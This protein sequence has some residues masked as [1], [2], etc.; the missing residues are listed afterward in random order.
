M[1]N[2]FLIIVLT[3]F[4]LFEIESIYSQVPHRSSINLEHGAHR[5]G[6]RTD[7]AMENWRNYGLGQF[8]HWGIYSIPGG[9]WDGKK[10]NGAAEWIRSW[11]GIPNNI[12]DN[13]YQQFNPEDFDAKAWAKQAKEMGAR[14]MIITTK[15]HDGFCLWPSQYTNYTIANTPYKKD[16]IKELVDAYTNEG[17]DVYLYFSIIDWNYPGY[18]SSI[19]NK[20]DSLAYESFKQFTRNQL[21]ELLK[22]YPET[23][24]LWFDGT[25]DA[26]WKEQ[27]VFAD[28]LGNE[29]RNIIFGLII[30]SRF[31][32]DEFGNR[33]FDANGDMMGDYEQGWE[34]KIPDNISQLSGNDWDCVMTIPN[35]QWG[36]NE[37]WDGHVK[38]SFELIEMLVKCVSLDGNFV[39]NFGPN[40][41]GIIRKEETSRAK[42]IGEWMK[43]NNEAIYDCGYAEVEKQD[44]GYFTQNRSSGQTYMAVF[45]VPVN[46][47]LKIKCPEKK[48]IGRVAPLSSP[49]DILKIEKINK[50]EYYI[51]LNDK[52]LNTPKVFTVEFIDEEKKGVNDSPKI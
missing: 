18:R 4:C 21:I 51:I 44:W 39:L 35:N 23:K 16:I 26:A 10:Y 40:S 1:K 32:P 37:N 19:K 15:H 27:A 28:S 13:L 48:K 7:S 6:R 25:W 22:M 50:Q 49:D 30:G 14:Y 36:Y 33:H 47:K 8:I 42:E 31:R 9:Q 24:G 29:L 12:Y 2:R 20:E 5:L 52:I 46:G 43:V 41:K 11:S 17:I 38:S 3:V 34:R 45:N